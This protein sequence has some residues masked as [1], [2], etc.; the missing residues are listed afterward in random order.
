[1]MVRPTILVAEPEPPEG[2]SA[3]KLV[4]ETAKFN[5]ITAHSGGEAKELLEKFN[6][7]EAIVLH[8]S[9][10]GLDCKKAIA[11]IKAQSVRAQVIVITPV[12]NF[13]CKNAD[14]LL[15]SHEPQQLLALL[16]SMF[17][18]PRKINGSGGSWR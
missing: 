2:V 14:H 8:S 6:N 3:R 1:M 17:G 7:V 15:N 16:R 9:L 18:D 11:D 4:L 12:E 13:D 10:A 5:V